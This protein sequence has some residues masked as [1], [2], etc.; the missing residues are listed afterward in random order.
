M[1]FLLEPALLVAIAAALV[2]GLARRSSPPRL[3]LDSGTFPAGW[4][5]ALAVALLVGLLA[6]IVVQ[7]VLGLAG[8]GA[9]VDLEGASYA[10]L[11]HA[12]ALLGAFL[13]AWWA[14]AGF[15]ALS[16]FL[17][18][19]SREI[20]RRLAL[21]AG[22][23]LGAWAITIGTMSVVGGGLLWLAGGLDAGSDGTAAIAP[24]SA[25]VVPEAI[26]YLVGLSVP[27]RL[28]LVASAGV[29]EEAFFRGFLQP[30]AGLLLSS[31]LFTASHAGY[32]SPLLMVGVL[33]LSLVLGRLFRERQDV[34]PCMVAHSVFDAVQLLVVLPLVAAAA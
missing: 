20:A 10:R 5:A 25:G 6:T 2:L 1:D 23:G 7:P 27:R 26:E 4:R 22:A 12:H 32:G 33:L 28:L 15:P 16:D 29:F 19:P 14:L 24:D 11:F 8:P 31:L 18:L 13:L 34:L 17:S 30:R 3:R 9:T 21:G